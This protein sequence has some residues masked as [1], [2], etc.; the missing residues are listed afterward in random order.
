M[1]WPHSKNAIRWTSQH[2]STIH[3]TGKTIETTETYTANT[4]REDEPIPRPLIDN[5]PIDNTKPVLNDKLTTLSDNSIG[6]K[7]CS[8][9]FLTIK[10]RLIF[11]GK[12]SWSSIK[13]KNENYSVSLTTL[14]GNKISTIFSLVVIDK[15]IFDLLTIQELC[16]KSN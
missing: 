1:R 8:V 11:L 15:T 13:E 2:N 9:S 3:S 7:I 4:L 16:S 10:K 6:R 5:T 12:S 14:I